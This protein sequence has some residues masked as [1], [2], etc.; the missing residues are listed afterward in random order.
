MRTNKHPSLPIVLLGTKTCG[1][2]L[3]RSVSRVFAVSYRNKDWK[4][5]K[6]RI[7]KKTNPIRS[8]SLLGVMIHY[9]TSFKMQHFLDFV[10][11]RN[12]VT[13]QVSTS[14]EVENVLRFIVADFPGNNYLTF[15][16]I[17]SIIS[18]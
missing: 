5:N 9:K 16:S 8:G 15:S 14:L 4:K 3:E 12:A 11:N 7:K 18:V 6:C 2:K 13:V 10:R 1:P 17:S